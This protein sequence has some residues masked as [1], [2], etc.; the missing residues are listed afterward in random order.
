[1]SVDRKTAQYLYG[2]LVKPKV[3]CGM[4][5]KEVLEQKERLAHGNVRRLTKSGLTD[6]N[7]LNIKDCLEAIKFNRGLIAELKD[8][9]NE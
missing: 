9:S 7:M 4:N 8:W 3:W 5:Y 1:M 2:P 6:S